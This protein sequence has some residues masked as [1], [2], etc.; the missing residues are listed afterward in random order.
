MVYYNIWWIMKIKNIKQLNIS[1]LREKA[2]TIAEAGLE[3]IDTRAAIT[4][5]VHIT[6]DAIHI[7]NEVIPH[8][9]RGKIIVIGIGKCALEGARALE[10]IL[11]DRIYAGA[12]IDVVEGNL[13]YLK[14][15]TGDH[16]YPTQRNVDAT[17]AIITLLSNLSLRDTVIFLISGGG[18]TLLCQPKDMTCHDEAHIL[19]CL[20][21]SGASIEK[22][23]TIRK[24]ISLARGGYMAQYAYP[25]RVISLIFSDVPGNNLEFIASGPTIKDTTTLEQ[26]QTIIKEY[27]VKRK[28]HIEKIELFETP[29]DDKYF[30]NVKNLLI[31][32]NDIALMAMAEK[33][34]TLGYNPIVCSNCLQGEARDV[35]INLTKE[36]AGAAPKTVLLYGGETTVTIRHPGKGGRCQELGLSALPTLPN[37]AILIPFA[38]D[39]KDN[40][41]I[42]GPIC[43]AL[44][45]Q[46]AHDHSL[47]ITQHLEENNSYA[48]FTITGDVLITG[49]TGSNVSDLI[50]GIKD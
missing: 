31:I 39:G 4:R 6:P 50:V 19:K 42:A 32:S 12:V 27:D 2:L 5:S 8:A 28:C 20:F 46:H 36:L 33:A 26:A 38:S 34:K 25:A 49:S 22:I 11:K 23:N 16:P 30:A 37:N 1:P 3:A 18:S 29:K 35:G 47:D 43:D 48:F 15:Y 14:T 24:H 9:T 41:D 44:T 21:M 40:T 13:T 10:E 17:K 45:L 7:Q